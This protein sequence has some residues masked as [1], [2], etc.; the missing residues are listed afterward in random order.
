MWSTIIQDNLN[1][2]EKMSA[3]RC[4]FSETHSLTRTS[5]TI[6]ADLLSNSESDDSL[7]CSV[8]AA[9]WVDNVWGAV[10]GAVV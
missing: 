8:T 2:K 7:N 3:L 4:V 10:T 9:A 6:I 1:Y 5:T